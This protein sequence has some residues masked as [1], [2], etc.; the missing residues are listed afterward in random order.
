MPKYKKG[1]NEIVVKISEIK[2]SELINKNVCVY[3]YRH[4]LIA[5][6]SIKSIKNISSCTFRHRITLH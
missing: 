1:T 2:T 5:I 4:K 3:K 6:N